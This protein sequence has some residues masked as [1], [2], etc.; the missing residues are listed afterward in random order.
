VKR[1]RAFYESR[2]DLLLA[3]LSSELASVAT[4]T[5]PGGGFYSWLT[6][7]DAA[8]DTSELAQHARQHRVA[9]V[10]GAAFYPDDQGRSSL[11]LSYSRVSDADITAGVSRLADA[12]RGRA[13]R[14]APATSRS[15]GEAEGRVAPGL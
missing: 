8:I 10:P 4:W 13:A 7:T 11:R 12:A 6:F 14:E 1:A 5:R 3:A 9:F 15:A 2:R